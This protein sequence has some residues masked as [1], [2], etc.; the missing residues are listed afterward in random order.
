[1][2]PD[3]DVSELLATLDHYLSEL[4]ANG[5]RPLDVQELEKAF[6]RAVE[7]GHVDE[8][9]MTE[10]GREYTQLLLRGRRH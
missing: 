5:T 3:P 10:A 7:R 1:M 8:N 4:T 6:E 2:T 9:G